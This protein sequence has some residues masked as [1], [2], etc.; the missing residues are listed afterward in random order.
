M[1]RRRSPELSDADFA[2]AV[3]KL[4][5]AAMRGELEK[6]CGNQDREVREVAF[7]LAIIQQLLERELRA[8]FA[9]AD[10]PGTP[11]LGA[12]AIIDALTSGRDH[13]IWRHV[14]GLRSGQFRPQNAP[15][16][17]NEELAR[18]VVVGL[19]RAYEVTANVSQHAA[20]KAVSKDCRFEDFAFGV[21]QIKR[22]DRTCRE[23]QDLGPDAFANKFIEDATELG[24]AIQAGDA[25][26]ARFGGL[27][28]GELV[29]AVGRKYV[30]RMWA[31]PGA[32]GDA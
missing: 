2:S 19:V 16:N 23:Q 13:S 18:V 9:T 1:A 15:P 31:V 32:T 7:P 5:S 10:V 21:E 17:R 22:W 14:A 11:I 20:I 29:L 24:N 3:I 12:L 8:G 25:R 26:T 28:A 30:W 4:Y 27:D 6:F